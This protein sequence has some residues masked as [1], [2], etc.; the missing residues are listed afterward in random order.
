MV[1][2]KVLPIAGVEGGATGVVELFYIQIIA[3][4]TQIYTCVGIHRTVQQYKNILLISLKIKQK[5][6]LL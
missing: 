2:R 3:M 5:H 6:F 1:N 4:A